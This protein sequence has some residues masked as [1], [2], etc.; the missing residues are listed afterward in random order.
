VVHIPALAETV[1]AQRGEGCHWVS[2]SGRHRATRRAAVSS[3]DSL[4]KAVLLTTDLFN[5][6]TDERR[7]KL[8][9]L[10]SRARVCRTWADCYGYVLVAT[11]RA[12]LMIDSMVK[13][14]DCAPM[15]P[16]LQEAGGTFSDW[17]GKHH[18]YGDSGLATNGRLLKEALAALA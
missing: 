10:A 2:G 9:G 6:P 7:Q 17:S 12:E 8:L 14:W 4:E 3:I 5:A 11:G 1:Y 13:I 18:V 15:Q 16:I